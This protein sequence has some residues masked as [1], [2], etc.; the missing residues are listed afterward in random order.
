[1]L[2][3]S[4]NQHHSLAQFWLVVGSFWNK[5]ELAMFNMEQLAPGLFTEATPAAP[6]L[7]HKHSMLAEMWRSAGYKIE[8]DR[9][10]SLASNM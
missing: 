10:W 4:H 3:E 1:M 5:M 8:K 9:P 2:L 7:S 6:V